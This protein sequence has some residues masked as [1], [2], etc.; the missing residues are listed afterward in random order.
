MR[1]ARSLHAAVVL[2]LPVGVFGVT[3]IARADTHRDPPAGRARHRPLASAS[4]TMFRSLL[5]VLLASVLWV[6]VYVA[7][8]A[9]VVVR[10]MHGRATAD[11]AGYLEATHVPMWWVVLLVMPP[12]LLFGWWLLRR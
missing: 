8:S 12:V 11:R 4:R 2:P 10:R 6:F 5:S 1:S 9:R 7:I 3:D